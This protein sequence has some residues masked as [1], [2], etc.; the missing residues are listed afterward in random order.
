MGP[1]SAGAHCKLHGFARQIESGK[2]RLRWRTLF[3]AQLAGHFYMLE[4]HRGSTDQS[5]NVFMWLDRC[6][7]RARP[8]AGTPGCSTALRPQS[9]QSRRWAPKS[10]MR[11]EPRS[12]CGFDRATSKDMKDSRREL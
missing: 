11:L 12:P 9:A 5:L 4:R 8:H 6:E 2:W 3:I 1:G 10:R 7:R